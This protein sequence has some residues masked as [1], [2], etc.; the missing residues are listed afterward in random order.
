MLSPQ[1]ELDSHGRYESGESRRIAI[2]R[3]CDLNTFI[4]E[5]SPSMPHCCR[6]SDVLMD[7]PV[8]LRCHE[9]AEGAYPTA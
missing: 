6:T 5:A 4:C 1:R 2:G 9:G 3:N 7:S 8:L